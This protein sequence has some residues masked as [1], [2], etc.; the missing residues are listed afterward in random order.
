MDDDLD[1]MFARLR[2]GPVPA[3]LDGLDGEVMAGLAAGRERLAGRRTL[4]LACIVAAGVGLWGG[5]AGPSP[6][7]AHDHDRTLLALPD[8]APSHLLGS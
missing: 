5:L 3:A 7:Q 6:A 2:D 4:L 1:R 8:A